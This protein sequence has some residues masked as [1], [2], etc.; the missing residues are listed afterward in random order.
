[1][2]KVKLSFQGYLID[3]PIVYLT[4][5]K[6]D[7]DVVGPQ[8]SARPHSSPLTTNGKVRDKVSCPGGSLRRETK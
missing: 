3:R 7:V 8:N 6:A 4:L 1:M 5:A 2:C